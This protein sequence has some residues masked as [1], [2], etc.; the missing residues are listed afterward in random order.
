MTLHSAQ[1]GLASMAGKILLI[2]S[3]MPPICCCCGTHRRRH[4]AA[5]ATGRMMQ[6]SLSVAH[7]SPLLAWPSTLPIMA[8]FSGTGV[9]VTG[10]LEMLRQL[11]KIMAGLDVDWEAA[12]AQLVG[13]IP[14]HILADK[15]SQ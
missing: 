14:A 11:N 2:D 8:S 7:W 6:I 9:N 10:D 5:P 3:S 1:D 15:H 13:D 12:L 4:Y